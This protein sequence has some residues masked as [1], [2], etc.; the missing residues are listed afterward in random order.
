MNKTA[1][2]SPTNPGFINW[3]IILLLGMI[4][5]GSFLFIKIS[6]ETVGPL[7]S[8]AIRTLIGGMILIAV[9][10][11]R[12]Q[13]LQKINTARAWS[14]SVLIGLISIALPLYL[15]SWGQQHVT[16]AY[17]G[18][19]MSAIPLLILPLVYFFSP[20][21][22]IGPRRVIG[23]ILGFAGLVI[24]F[25]IN[26]IQLSSEKSQLLGQLA[27]FMATVCYAVGSIL[28]R[29]A[30]HMPQ[31]EFAAVTLISA[32]L[33]LT[34]LALYYEG[35]PYQL[36]FKSA[37]ALLYL[38]FFASALGAVLRI[39]V[40][41]SAG[42]IFMS[43]TTYQVPIWALLYSALFLDE[44]L[45]KTLFIALFLLIIGIIISQSRSLILFFK[46]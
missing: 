7:T 21:E 42:S 46:T 25:D 32:T 2:I 34:P 5:G 35:L 9:V 31:I 33:I 26:S 36:S 38:A 11:A 45:P 44:T 13:N 17:A 40:T 41:K 4:W 24:L 15:L 22:G 3:F 12:G 19:S 27:C 37:L 23:L 14:F 29:N 6:L 28:T 8:A 1:I 16:S 10:L 43:L 18:V 20:D 30:P 39:R